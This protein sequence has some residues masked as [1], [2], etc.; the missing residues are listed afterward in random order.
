MRRRRQSGAAIVELA[1]L[2]PLLVI[3]LLGT[4]HF[5]LV[6]FYYTRVDK[7]VHD[8][9]RYAAMRTYSDQP[10]D[11]SLYLQA[12]ANTAATG[13]PTGGGAA[14]APGFGAGQ[15]LV[16]VDQPVA[17][18]RP[19]VVTVTVNGYTI[20]GAMGLVTLANKPSA[21]FPFLGRYVAPELP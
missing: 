11:S 10:G 20:P 13:L 7:A 14:V 21:T 8:A 3:L 9:A 17:G 5:G 19:R 12:V 4:V 1:L 6:M 15:V 18:V 16:T 2:L